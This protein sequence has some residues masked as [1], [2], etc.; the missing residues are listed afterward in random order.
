MPI[1]PRPNRG[2]ESSPVECIPALLPPFGDRPGQGEGRD[3][4][5]GRGPAEHWLWPRRQSR[6]SGLSTPRGRRRPRR[7][8]RSERL[9]RWSFPPWSGKGRPRSAWP[10]DA[11]WRWSPG[12]YARAPAAGLCLPSGTKAALSRSPPPAG[13]LTHPSS[14]GVC[15]FCAGANAG[16]LAAMIGPRSCARAALPGLHRPRAR[17]RRRAGSERRRH[18]PNC[19]LPQGEPR[20]PWRSGRATGRW[21]RR[22][23][24]AGGRRSF[25]WDHSLSGSLIARSV[26]DHR[27]RMHGRRSRRYGRRSGFP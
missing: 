4:G 25:P 7:S 5:P 14:A 8:P 9:R 22:R 16:A 19:P 17:R 10:R 20:R 1:R 6:Q 18:R 24:D 21:R 26:G 15:G 27:G 2:R 13:P 11:H 3:L 23:Q 12:V